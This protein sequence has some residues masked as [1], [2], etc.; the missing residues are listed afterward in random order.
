[1]AELVKTISKDTYIIVSV[2]LPFRFEGIAR[3]NKALSDL[4]QLE[5][6]SSVDDLFVIRNQDLL[7]MVSNDFSFPEALNLADT[8]RLSYIKSMLGFFL[9]GFDF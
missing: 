6:N 2:T 7:D 3:S 4:K 5:Q 9:Y 1:M 8:A